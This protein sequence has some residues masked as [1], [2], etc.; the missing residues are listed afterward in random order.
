MRNF[1]LE[2]SLRNKTPKWQTIN[3]NITIKTKQ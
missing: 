2:K 1:F 3:I